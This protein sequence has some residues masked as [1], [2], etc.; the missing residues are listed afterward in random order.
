MVAHFTDAYRELFHIV[1]CLRR[2]QHKPLL[3]HIV[4]NANRGVIHIVRRKC[5]TLGERES[6]VSTDGSKE[7][8]NRIFVCVI[9]CGNECKTLSTALR[10]TRRYYGLQIT[11]RFVFC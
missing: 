4:G 11:C 1:G 9:G 8:R 3:I 6:R 10:H 2:E 5:V 7:C